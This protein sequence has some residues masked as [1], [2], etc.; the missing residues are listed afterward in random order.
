MSTTD[1][2][3]ALYQSTMPSAVRLAY[4]LTGDTARAEDTAQEAFLKSAVKLGSMRDPQRFD[5][6]LRRAVV[7][8]ALSDH[9]SEDRRL[10]RML[11]V[12]QLAPATTTDLGDVIADHVDLVGAVRL[13]P[14][15]QRAAVVLRYWLDLPEAEIADALG[16]AAGTVKSTLARA[17]DSLRREVQP[18][19]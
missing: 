8:T 11:R 5:A 9:R 19:V 16:C 1:E 18:H 17:L 13:L 4:L 6:Y 2:I 12:S 3:G 10:A 14:A 15:R 7:R